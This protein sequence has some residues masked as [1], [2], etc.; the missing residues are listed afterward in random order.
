MKKLRIGVVG[1][2]ISGLS[3]AWLLSRAHQ[4]TLF[5]ADARLG[6][7]A[8]T[9]RLKD[10]AI[11]VGFIVFNERTYPN[12][13]ALFQH[14]GV[15][16]TE[17][18]MGFS[19]SLENGAFEYSG[20]SLTQLLGSP[21]SAVSRQ[22]WSMLSDL[23]RFYRSAKSLSRLIPDEMSLGEFLAQHRF[24][25]VF[26]RRHLMPIAAA[27]WSSSPGLML[28]YPAK[29]FIDFFDNHQL[30]T[31]GARSKWRTVRGGSATYVAKLA[32]EGIRIHK[33]DAVQHVSRNVESHTVH[34]ASGHSEPFDHVVLAIHADQSLRILEQ[35][36]AEE[37]AL[38]APFRYSN[39]RVVL[40]RDVS[41]MPRRRRHWTSWN[42][43]GSSS[44][45][46]CGVTYWMNSLQ[47]L[48]TETQHFVS[49]N[50]P[51]QPDPDLIDLSFECTHPIFSAET[52]RAQKQL[53]QMQGKQNTWFCGA[54]F[55]AGFHEDG[56]QAGLAVAEALGG[57][58]RPWQVPNPSGRIYLAPDTNQPSHFQIGS[59]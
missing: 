34:C 32:G 48:Q 41:L 10:V 6:G 49:L 8:H 7:H 30:L 28:T 44:S 16:T 12:L 37:A 9:E 21:R 58:K 33:N 35:P 53:W 18:E 39:N 15:E 25:E 11:D 36:S 17:T 27:I 52:L 47:N 5:E 54:Y 2:G 26:I 3:C 55:G 14:L 57:V 31:L 46:T 51:E 56:L 4:V 20:G 13:T 42:Y 38:L 50:P 43:V 40:H 45:K 59:P 1:S 23:A 29:A 24:G 19:V 22:H